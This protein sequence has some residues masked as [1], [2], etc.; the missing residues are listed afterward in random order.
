[1]TKTLQNLAAAFIGESQA[2]NRYTYYASTAKKEGY[3]QI[4]AIFLETA[5]QEK[6]HAKQLLKLIKELEA[7]L[8]D[9]QPIIV[10]A[11]V[12]TVLDGTLKNLQAAAA[13]EKHEY[14]RMYPDFAKIADE[15]GLVDI[16]A[17][18]RAI[19]RAEEHHEERYNKLIEEVSAGT[20]FNKPAARAWVCRNCGYEHDG[21][22]AP[23]VCPA[24][25]H[26][27]GY[28]MVKSENY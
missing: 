5:D 19:A 1:M 18:L 2:R 9:K 3:E 20:V 6:E 4:S 14:S 15:E 13:G 16:A 8:S 10:E 17:Q 28:F 22:E 21:E 26:Q 25:K 27:R 11:E 7:K 12:P 24:C 23:T